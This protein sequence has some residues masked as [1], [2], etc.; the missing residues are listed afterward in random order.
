MRLILLTSTLGSSEKMLVEKEGKKP[1]YIGGVYFG[2]AAL[3]C[4]YA[5]LRGE[6]YVPVFAV[7]PIFYMLV[8]AAVVGVLAY[9]YGLAASM[10]SSF[11]DTKR[12]KKEFDGVGGALGGF[13][14]MLAVAG[15]LY[16]AVEPANKGKMFDLYAILL[17]LVSLLMLAARSVQNSKNGGRFSFSKLR[18]AMMELALKPAISVIFV[19]AVFYFLVPTSREI[20]NINL[21]LLAYRFAAWWAVCWLGYGIATK[22][23]IFRLFAVAQAA[24]LGAAS[25]FFLYLATSAVSNQQLAIC[26]IALVYAFLAYAEFRGE[27]D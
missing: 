19:L 27:L 7:A 23:D 14:V 16:N 10:L 24:V 2:F 9:F 17:V 1:E 8:T 5:L 25:L 26:G 13:F 21:E 6:N 12:M 20:G 22:K 15:V 11:K 3:Y 4:I 18:S